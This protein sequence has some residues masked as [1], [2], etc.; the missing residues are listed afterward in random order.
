MGHLYYEELGNM[1][2]YDINGNYPQPGWG[3]NNTG[4]FNNLVDWWYWSGTEYANFPSDAWNFGMNRGG[5]NSNFK[6]GLE[7]G[8]AVRSGQVS[9]SSI[10]V[11]GAIMLLGAGLLWVVGLGRKRRRDV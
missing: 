3:L 7:Y 11:P 9:V 1:G 10:P 4:D 2:Y 8:L 6:T 5:Q